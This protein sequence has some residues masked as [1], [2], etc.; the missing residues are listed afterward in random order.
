MCSCYTA[1][2]LNV[3]DSKTTYQCL[4]N[5]VTVHLQLLISTKI[6]ATTDKGSSKTACD[7]FCFS[8]PINMVTDML[9][10]LNQV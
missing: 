9:S 1:C 7:E 8:K 10:L 5:N 2:S 4:F 6:E 3:M